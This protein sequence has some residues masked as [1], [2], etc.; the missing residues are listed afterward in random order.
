M[1]SKKFFTLGVALIAA[2]S[3]GGWISLSLG[4]VT[5]IESYLASSDGSL[6]DLALENLY[7]R[8]WFLTWIPFFAGVFLAGKEGLSASK[9]LFK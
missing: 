3:I 1:P 8:I 2:S 7:L 6:L 4:G 9:R 5:C